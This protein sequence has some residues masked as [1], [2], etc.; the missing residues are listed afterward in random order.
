MG[1]FNKLEELARRVR[2]FADIPEFDYD[3][4]SKYYDIAQNCIQLE[5]IQETIKYQKKLK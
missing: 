1:F 3:L 5:L 2:D 4:L